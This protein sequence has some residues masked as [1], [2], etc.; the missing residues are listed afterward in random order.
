MLFLA[1][2]FA[3]MS[4]N[5]Q[6]AEKL[7]DKYSKVEG[8]ECVDVLKM[9]NNGEI[10][11][12]E[13]TLEIG[14]LT[15]TLDKDKLHPQNIL[16]H[17]VVV[18]EECKSSLAKKFWKDVKS[19]KNY[20]VISSSDEDGLYM[21]ILINVKVENGDS[22]T[23]TLL[24]MAEIPDDNDETASFGVNLLKAKKVPDDEISANMEINQDLSVISTTTN[25]DEILFVLNGVAHPEFNSQES[26]NKYCDENNLYEL[27]LVDGVFDRDK[28]KEKFPDSNRKYVFYF[29]AEQ[30]KDR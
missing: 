11:E 17:N 13:P 23:E 29:T 2:M 14:P 27:K 25:G 21:K 30:R 3:M 5:A 7:L 22:I 26:I 20:S 4:V 19:L 6:K 18:V 15:I 8:A 28:V 16:A 10:K 24:A 9:L 1:S 12:D